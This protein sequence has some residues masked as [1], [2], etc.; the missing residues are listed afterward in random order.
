VQPVRGVIACLQRIAL[1]GAFAIV[2]AAL[3]PALAQGSAQADARPGRDWAVDPTTPGENLPPV[4][5]SLFDHLFTRNE[6]SRKVYDVPFPFSAVLKKLENEVQPTSPGASPIKSVLIPLG[7]SLQRTAAAPQ[8]YA[9]PRVVVTVDTEPRTSATSAGM[10]LKDR[11]YLGYQEKA[12]VIEVISYNEA[13]GRF[14][15]Q[16]VK[17]YRAG[18]VPKVFYASRAI[19]TACHQNAAP[20]FPRQVW[21]ETNANRAI[22][23]GLLK[24]RRS[25]YG[26]EPDRGVDI[27]YAVDNATDRANLFSAYQLLWRDGCAVVAAEERAAR[28]RAA[29]FL[30]ALQYRLSGG[31][32]F[33]ASSARV[34]EGVV[35]VLVRNA[36]EYWPS[37]LR[38]PNPDLP[39][40]DPL[41]VS[42][43]TGLGVPTTPPA[44][45]YRMANNANIPAAFDPLAPRPPIDVWQMRDSATLS[46]LVA[47]LAEFI[48]T[49]D[50]RALS[51][52]LAS[53][54]QRAQVATVYES[55]CELSRSPRSATS[56][57]LDFKCSTAPAATP[58]AMLEGRLYVEG[59]ARVNGSIDRLVLADTAQAPRDSRD[60]DIG[61]RAIVSRGARREI[62]LELTRNGSLARRADGARLESLQLGWEEG[63]PAVKESGAL[64]GRAVVTAVNDFDPVIAAAERMVG[65]TIAG[66][67]DA[68]SAKPFRRAAL[69]APLLA[70]LHAKPLAWCCVSD[71]GMPAPVMDVHTAT[72]SAKTEADAKPV[73]LQ[74]FFRYCATCH[75]TNE[76]TPPNFLQ[77][78][79][80]AVTSNIAHCA[81]R[82]Y[83]RLSMW[84][85]APEQRAKT[86]MPPQY[87][88]Y[89]FHG[90]PQSWRESAE[91]AALKAYVERALQTEKG[92]TPRPDELLALGYENLRACLP[93]A[94]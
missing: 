47:G 19:C 50:A 15:F 12:E 44:E 52:Q 59:P 33:D 41:V 54:S 91:L 83:V 58:S 94:S 14:E 63:A 36:R 45:A 84:Q 75:Q 43:Q 73:A 25:F 79:A 61:A 55:D 86:P 4:G 21:D 38:L 11:I 3:S 82:L 92:K 87:A 23:A 64:R 8:F 42:A 81:E 49:A 71:T 46:R 1:G 68:F 56:Y 7:R 24:E 48:T 93:E 72:P 76:R 10:L 28:C 78:S 30:A 62:M 27:P 57:R 6:G 74:P 90:S 67:I 17:D 32:Q 16:V 65:D 5:R 13:A 37:G 35:P 31:Q 20:I 9:F 77:G 39:N 85:I 2:L 69:M 60:L 18:G 26:L 22:A 80:N 29:L 66:K 40:R 53:E 34:R 51:A 89:G 70:E 88:L